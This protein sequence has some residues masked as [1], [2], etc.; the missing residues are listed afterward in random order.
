MYSK[1][2]M[3]GVLG[4]IFLVTGALADVFNIPAGHLDAAL[5][6]YT[7]QTGVT[8]LVSNDAIKGIRTRGVRSAF[9]RRS[10]LPLA[11]RH[12]LS[13]ASCF[14]RRDHNRSR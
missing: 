14:G 12:G 11:H 7:V 5:N 1:L 2:L 10:A 8:L 3:S 9:R 4:A 6:A 13:D